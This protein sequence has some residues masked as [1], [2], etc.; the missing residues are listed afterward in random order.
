MANNT[1]L[2]ILDISNNR[3]EGASWEPIIEAIKSN[4]TLESLVLSGNTLSPE[5]AVLL[6][7]AREGR[8]QPPGVGAGVGGT[9]GRCVP[10]PSAASD[11]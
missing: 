6:S 7:A 4:D 3:I 5:E 8:D 1:S 9:P 10:V 2:K 11:M